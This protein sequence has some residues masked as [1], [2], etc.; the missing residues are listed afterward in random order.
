M[1]NRIRALLLLALIAA[2][3]VRPEP[4]GPVQRGLLAMLGLEDRPPPTNH[5]RTLSDYIRRTYPWS[6]GNTHHT[7]RYFR[8]TEKASGDDCDPF[9]A[10]YHFKLNGI[11][12]DEQDLWAAELV[13]YRES[14]N[15][16]RPPLHRVRV[17]DVIRDGDVLLDSKVLARTD[18]GVWESFDV[19]PAVRRWKSGGY[20]Y[21]LRVK[22][23]STGKA[24]R[25]R[26]RRAL[27]EDSHRWQQFEPLLVVHSR[28]STIRPTRT[29]RSTTRKGHRRKGRKDHCRRHALYV[30]FMDVGWNDWI[31]APPGYNAYYCYGEC[32]YPLADHMNATNHAIVQALVNSANPAAVPRACCV[33][34]ELSPISMLYKDKYDN[35]VLKNYQDMVVEGCGCR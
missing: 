16:S 26:L 19:L 20:N 7:I 1:R 15:D 30:D 17:F 5:N 6:T 33:P 13:L 3:A 8:S 22:V 21:G 25:L 27:H 29:K 9:Q 34:T 12:E 10:H 11:P 2:G 35:V 32:A 28:A 23:A 18:D 31:I 4:P 14:S 24:G